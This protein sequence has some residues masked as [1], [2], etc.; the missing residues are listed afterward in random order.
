[1]PKDLG[2]YGLLISCQ[3]IALEASDHDI[4]DALDAPLCLISCS[5]L[6]AMSLV[7]VRGMENRRL[8]GSCSDYMQE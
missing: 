5:A 7:V 6:C 4:Y 1:M 2:V 8:G 3:T